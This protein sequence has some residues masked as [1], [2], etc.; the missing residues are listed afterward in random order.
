MALTLL[1]IFLAVLAAYYVLG[2][3]LLDFIHRFVKEFTHT[4]PL[5]AFFRF[6]PDPRRGAEG[7][8]R[9]RAARK[10]TRQ[11]EGAPPF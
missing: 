8:R 1:L 10:R 6:L 7:A 11:G 4:F 5:C 2:A 9:R 3:P